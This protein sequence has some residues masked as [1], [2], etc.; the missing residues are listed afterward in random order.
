MKSSLSE[1]K[2]SISRGK[3][4]LKYET[5]INGTGFSRGKSIKKG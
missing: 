3:M 1:R 2:N 5:Y 4:D